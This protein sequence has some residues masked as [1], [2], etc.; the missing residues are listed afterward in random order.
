MSTDTET[1]WQ[2]YTRQQYEA[3]ERKFVTVYTEIQAE[4]AEP[5]PVNVDGDGPDIGLPAVLASAAAIL[6]F[7]ILALWVLWGVIR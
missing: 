6:T 5:V 4:Q 3:A 2:A 7:I 1:A